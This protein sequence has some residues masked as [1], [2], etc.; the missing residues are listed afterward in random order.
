[1]KQIRNRARK[2]F[3]SVLLTLLSIVQAIALETLWEASRHRADLFDPSL[4]TVTSWLQLAATLLIII[5]IWLAYVGMVMRFR[6]TPQLADLISPFF[7][8]LL[9]F[10]LI[11]MTNP[12]HLGEWFVVLAVIAALVTYFT[13]KLFQ[14]AR[15]DSENHEFFSVVPA[16]TW[17]DHSVRIF[18]AAMSA[19]IGGWLWQSGHT[20]WFALVAILLVW[21][22]IIHQIWIAAKYWRISMGDDV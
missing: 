4:L 1:M 14:R 9:Q 20:G 21:L 17:R 16:A 6:I 18:P 10:L 3:P 7:V 11:E 13:H 2:S 22:S 5:F 19:L 15:R 8:G 12:G